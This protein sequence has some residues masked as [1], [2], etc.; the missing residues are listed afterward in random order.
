MSETGLLLNAYYEWLYDRLNDARDILVMCTEEILSD[1]IKRRNF[2]DFGEEK[3]S[4]YR[5]ACVA[6]IDERIEAYNPT[7]VQYTFDNLRSGLVHELALQL[8]WCDSRA[9]FT[10]LLEA[11]RRKSEK[12]MTD[13]KLRQLAD[14][15]VKENGAFPDRSI[16]S[17]Y[18]KQP[19]LNK[20]P[21]Y[22]VA[23]AIEMVIRG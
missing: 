4:A 7:G 22:F 12:N 6:F 5:D 13:E 8:D 11:A 23:K 2:A 1:E 9:E 19:E 15:L 16:I 21:D 20:L 17:E 18:E 14:E 10:A 3:Y